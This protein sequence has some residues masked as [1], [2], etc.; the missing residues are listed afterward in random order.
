VGKSKDGLWVGSIVVGY[1]PETGNPR[2]KTVYGKTKE[3]ARAK[4]LQL[5][6]KAMAGLAD[7]PDMSLK[8]CLKFYLDTVVK[9]RVDAAT[10]T[11]HKQRVNDHLI[12]HLGHMALTRLTPFMVSQLYQD[13]EQEGHSVD[14]RN[15]VG[16]LLRRCL[17]H[18]VELG[19]V[20][21]NVAKKIPL[22][23]V[24]P[25]EMHPVDEDQVKRFL[26]V[27][28]RHRLYP[29]FLLALDSGMRQGEIIALEWTDL[30]F[31]TGIV[32]ITK[33]AK[34]E[35]TSKAPGGGR[36]KEVKT[37]AGRRRIRLTRRTLDALT[38]LK[39]RSHDRIVFTKSNQGRHGANRDRLNYYLTKDSLLATFQL[40]LDKAGLPKIRFHD[41]RHTHATLALLKTKN[42]KAVSARLGHADIRVTLDRY[43]HYLPVME[44]EM[45]AA[46]EDLLAPKPAAAAP[47]VATHL[48]E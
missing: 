7:A 1:H 6:Q 43:A 10:Y 46:M 27:A 44:E 13:L 5:Q 24:S 31:Q 4:L 3:E 20:R 9:P 47:P 2:R 36:I 32:S 35:A 23:R 42:I 30:D 22:P 16:Q 48:E 34:K 19:L 29:L 41:L 28:S 25:Q 33:S 37:K 14:L 11:L 40:L 17:K 18:A 38:D 26:A 8:V 12:P 45:V 15:K 39:A 21:D